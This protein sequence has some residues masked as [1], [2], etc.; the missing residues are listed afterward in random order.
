MKHKI[1]LLFLFSISVGVT[2]ISVTVSGGCTPSDEDGGAGG[3]GGTA[4]KSGAGG[5]QT[6]SVELHQSLLSQR[7]ASEDQSKFEPWSASCYPDS[8]LYGTIVG[9]KDPPSSASGVRRAVNVVFS[10][11]GKLV[12]IEGMTCDP[13]FDGKEYNYYDCNIPFLCGCCGFN[14]EKDASNAWIEPAQGSWRSPLACNQYAAYRYV[15]AEVGTSGSGGRGGGASGSRSIGTGGR[16]GSNCAQCL[17]SC[18]GLPGCCSS[19]SGC[20]CRNACMPTSCPKGLTLCCGPYGD[21]ICVDDC[22]YY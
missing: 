7:R 11:E 16:S 4:E 21:C 22:P 9:T 10:K 3:K 19:G 5:S 17:N 18:Y 12:S 14:F 1:S 6:C 2:I 15:L 8:K 20:I 13:L